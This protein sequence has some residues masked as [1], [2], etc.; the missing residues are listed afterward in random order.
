VFNNLLEKH[1]AD[2]PDDPL[3]HAKNECYEFYM[4]I[5][6][7]DMTKVPEIL[8]NTYAYASAHPRRIIT[9]AA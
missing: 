9:M 1:K 3:Q 8:E 4:A 7:G 5:F 2:A 6:C